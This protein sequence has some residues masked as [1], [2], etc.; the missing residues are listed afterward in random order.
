MKQQHA[1][2]QVIPF[3]KYLR[4]A[5]IAYWSVRNKPMIHGLFEVDVTSA[6]AVLREHHARTGESLSFTAFLATCVAKAVDEHKEVQAFRQG[7]AHLVLF[8]DV[9]IYTPIEHDVAGQKYVIPHIIRAANRKTFRQLHDEIRAAQVADVRHLLTWLRLVP[10]VVYRP[11]VWALSGIGRRRPRLWKDNLGTVGLT[12][13]GMF[14][15]GAGWGIPPAMPAALMVTVGGIGEKQ[16]I[17]DGHVAVR[18]YLN[19]TVS[20]DHEIIDGAPAARFTRRLKALIESGYGLGDI[21]AAAEPVQ[22]TADGASRQKVEAM[23]A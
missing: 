12:A 11:I 7:G 16:V 6:R 23:R 5:A 15:D 1:D 17:V 2:A 14:G 9:D 13:V 18:E 20:V 8:D 4:L 21:T 10:T 19:L 22:A 3:P